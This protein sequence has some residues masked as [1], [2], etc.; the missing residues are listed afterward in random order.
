MKKFR[1]ADDSA[2]AIPQQHTM[3]VQIYVQRKREQRESEVIIH[4][5][6]G[7]LR[8]MARQKCIF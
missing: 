3:R 2:I 6:T 8:F 5:S 7:N 4:L 1:H